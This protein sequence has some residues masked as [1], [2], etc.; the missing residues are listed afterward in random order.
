MTKR[1]AAIALAAAIAAIIASAPAA[2]AN[3]APPKPGERIGSIHIKKIGLD[4]PL[5][6]GDRP[7]TFYRPNAFPPSLDHG[8]AVYPRSPLPGPSR[9]HTVKIAGHHVTHSHPFLL[10]YKLRKGDV[11]VIKTKY[12]G[13]FHYRVLGKPRST[14]GPWVPRWN[15]PGG[16]L[17]SSCIKQGRER[18]VAKAMLSWSRE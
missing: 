6:K 7:E 8:P 17:L 4:Q 10:L 5:F 2:S 18:L 13:E 3:S 14:G 9:Q 1:R 12:G 15:M 16:L 11:I